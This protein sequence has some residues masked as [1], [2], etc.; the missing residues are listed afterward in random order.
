MIQNPIIMQGNI[1][2]PV[3]LAISKKVYI[4]IH[5]ILCYFKCGEGSNRY[6]EFVPEDGESHEMEKLTS[7]QYGTT[8]FDTNSTTN[9]NSNEF[10]PANPFVKTKVI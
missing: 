6:T 5:F 2:Y 4:S 10:S 1:K 7:R 8:D 3:L 9:Q